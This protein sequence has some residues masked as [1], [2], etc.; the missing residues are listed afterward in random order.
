MRS[1]LSWSKRSRNANGL[2]QSSSESIQRYFYYLALLL[3]MSSSPIADSF[4]LTGFPWLA[5]LLWLDLDLLR[6]SVFP[7]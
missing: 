2:W 3:P 1:I 6:A 5:I 4:H 7:N